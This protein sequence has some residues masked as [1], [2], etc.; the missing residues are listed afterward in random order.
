MPDSHPTLA[1]YER[2]GMVYMNRRLDV[3]LNKD[4]EW[5]KKFK[6]PFE[7]EQKTTSD[8]GTNFNGYALITGK[9]SGITAIDIDDTE[10]EHN[11]HLMDMMTECTLVARTRKGYHYVFK[12]NPTIKGVAVDELA[13]DTRN[14]NNCLFCEPTRDVKNDVGEIIASY[15]WEKVPFEDEGLVE[16][17]D[18]VLQY[19]MELSPKYFK[20]VEKPVAKVKVKKEKTE[21]VQEEETEE[22]QEV[23]ATTV[24]TEVNEEKGDDLL[25]KIANALP[26]KLLDD[27][28]DWINIGLI[29]F[30][31]NLSLEQFKT[32][33]KRSKK[34][35]EAGCVRAWNS[36]KVD[37]SGRKITSASLWKM[38]KE[39][40][41]EKFYEMM[42]VREDFW[43][44]IE[45]LNHNDTSKYFYNNNPDAYVWN[46]AIGWYSL[47]KNNIWK[48]CDKGTPSGLKRHIADTMQLFAKE[49]WNAYNMKHS[50]ALAKETDETKRNQMKK[51]LD[52]KYKKYT[53][54]YKSFGSNEFCNGVIALLPSLYENETLEEFMDMNRYVFAFT[55]GLYDLKLSCFR[56]IMPGDYVS[57]TTGRPYPKTANAKAR[58]EIMAM[59]WS[60]FEDKE[61]ID[62]VLKV[63]STCLSGKNRFE[64]FYVMTGTGRNGKGVLSDFLKYV[65][66]NYFISADNTLFTKP[67]ERK[68]QPIPALVEAKPKR[69]MMVS[70]PEGDDK[71]QVG[72][73]KKATGGDAVEARTLN[74]KHIHIYVPPWMLF[75]QTN[76]IPRL[77]QTQQAV[78]DRMKIINFPFK[79]VSNPT[80]KNHRPV[81]PDLKDK[82]IKSDAWIDEFLLILIEKYNEIKDLKSLPAPNAVKKVTGEYFDDNNPLKSWLDECYIITK[83]ENDVIQ[84]S[85][86]KNHFM[87]WKNLPTYSD[88]KFKDAM[89]FN[90]LISEKASKGEHKNRMCYFGIKKKEVEPFPQE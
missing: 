2:S 81:N 90:N 23:S 11:Q 50:K 9:T 15:R 32:V 60:M 79:F 33:S 46:E 4:G 16:I 18:M 47:G 76:T 52:E 72:L 3:Y 20:G 36:F 31:E 65:F 26:V 85:I 69:I 7:W 73:I 89:S 61:V 68:D 40:N 86:L 82:L 14:D 80:E 24:S 41:K 1:M 66:G 13:L 62:Y 25:V 88:N 8:S 78:Q 59:F 84:S 67:L 55:D 54:A 35:D 12:Y 45:I 51:Q 21:E 29:F 19:L 87:G 30:N 64:E 10:L 57:T 74:S 71:L 43:N 42:E 48:A 83:D 75:F 34:Y 53:Y 37:R 6:F 38:L 56:C 22:V 39:H 28:S 70:E 27:Y 58:E 49:S 63:F 17:P 77:S 44:L 5:K